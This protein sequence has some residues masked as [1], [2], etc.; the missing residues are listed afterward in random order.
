MLENLRQDF[1]SSELIQDVE[2]EPVK[3]W[4]APKIPPVPSRVLGMTASQRFIISLLLFVM[5]FLLGAL[6]LMLTGRV[7]PPF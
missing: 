2:P 6:C 1:D 7:L 5:T 3:K 4:E